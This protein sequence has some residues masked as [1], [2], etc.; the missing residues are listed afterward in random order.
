MWLCLILILFSPVSLG[1]R[2]RACPSAPQRHRRHGARAATPSRVCCRGAK[3]LIANSCNVWVSR[4]VFEVKN[5]KQFQIDSLYFWIENACIRMPEREVQDFYVVLHQK[6]CVPFCNVS[7][8]TYWAL[9]YGI[10]PSIQLSSYFGHWSL[11]FTI[12]VGWIILIVL[13]SYYSHNCV[14]TVYI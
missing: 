14:I 4:N 11:D 13:T 10:I 12:S 1:E 3:G 5:P 9:V 2:R 8:F 6:G 7:C